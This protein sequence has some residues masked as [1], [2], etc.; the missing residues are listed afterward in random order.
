MCIF[1]KIMPDDAKEEFII[2]SHRGASGYEPENTVSS[3]RKAVALGAQMIEFDV[4]TSLEGELVIMHDSKVNRT[5]NGKGYIRDKTL[6]E[7]RELD[8]G[9]GEK[10]PTVEEVI[11]E[12]AGTKFVIELKEYNSEDKILDI[13]HKYKVINDVFIV[14]FHK[15]IL[16]RI[17]HMEP[18]VL[19]GLIKFFPFNI[20]KD[21]NF[22]NADMIA[23]FRYFITS[24]LVQKVH[25][26]KLELFAWTVNKKGLALKMK[27]LGI[28][29]IVTDNLDLLS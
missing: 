27:N 28:R 26:M 2:I 10:I 20:Y 1:K 16:K 24:G 17:K 7:L 13:I 15:R 3:F 11:S 8:A 4:R 14:S 12:F 9:N 25:D 29:G 6:E 5:T 19:T 18:D 22:C 21:C 23:V